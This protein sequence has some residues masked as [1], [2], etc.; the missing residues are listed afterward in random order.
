MTGLKWQAEH[1][2]F[3]EQRCCLGSPVPDAALTVNVSGGFF[4]GAFGDEGWI[5]RIAG[6][7]QGFASGSLS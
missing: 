5:L 1:P 6:Y 3:Q 4:D 7:H 2:R